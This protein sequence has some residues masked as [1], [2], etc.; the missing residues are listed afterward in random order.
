[1]LKF[2]ESYRNRAIV[3]SGLALSWI[4]VLALTATNPWAIAWGSLAVSLFS[5]TAGLNFAGHYG[6]QVLKSA[7]LVIDLQNKAIIGLVEE[8]ERIQKLTPEELVEELKREA[9]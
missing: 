9:R 1:M 4:V 3:F 7:Y 6:D 8:V 5:W 2:F